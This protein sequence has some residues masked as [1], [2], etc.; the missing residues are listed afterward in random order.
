[1]ARGRMLNKKISQSKQIDLLPD[2][3]C[4]L[5]A[6]WTIAHLDK[7]GVFSAE[8]VLVRSAIF[9][10]RLDITIEQIEH[11]L[12]EMEKVGLIQIFEANGEKW[13]WWP[14]FIR[15]QTGLR[16]DREGTEYP[17]PPDDDRQEAGQSPD[18][19]E[20]IDEILPDVSRKD[21]GKMPER[22]PPKRKEKKGRGSVKS[23]TPSQEMFGALAEICLI[24]W[25]L[26]TESQRG[27]LNQSEKLLRVEAR[28]SPNDLKEFKSW[29]IEY[30][31]RGKKGEPP[32]P[33]QVREKWQEFIDYR[34]KRTG[35]ING[36]TTAKGT[37]GGV[38]V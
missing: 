27:E 29:W 38:Y 12:S 32:T 33:T 20:T 13:Q 2:D 10:R 23:S 36:S 35:A 4:R 24:N 22:F 34:Q 30:D 26:A 15:N 14:S 3:T 9:P 21:A 16:S 7:N 37:D 25:R 11:Y 6:T 8:P 19:N 31:W 28:A 17:P 1:M 5:L 18:D